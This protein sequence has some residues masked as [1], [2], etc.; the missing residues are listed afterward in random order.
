LTAYC[1]NS[2]R[3]VV[4][5]LRAQSVTT[6]LRDVGIQS[7]VAWLQSRQ[8]LEV[9]PPDKRVLQQDL[10]FLPQTVDIEWR[11]D[12]RASRERKYSGLKCSVPETSMSLTRSMNR[13]VTTP[14]T[15]F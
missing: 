6:S 9:E 4:G 1:T 2:R 3:P 14:F 7:R 8:Q 13:K 15:T 10:L 11:F 5:D 12:A